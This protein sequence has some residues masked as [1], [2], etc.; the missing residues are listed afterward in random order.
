M[1]HT[2]K[3]LA[4]FN[5]KCGKC[6]KWFGPDTSIHYVAPGKLGHVD[7]NNPLTHTP[8]EEAEEVAPEPPTTPVC[9][10]CFVHKPCPCDD[11]L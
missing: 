2:R 10:D 1:S 3:F 4:K 6:E 7:C 9:T 11:D 8:Y 5:G